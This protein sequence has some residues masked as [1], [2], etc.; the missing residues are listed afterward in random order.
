MYNYP[1][2]EITLI[3]YISQP[4]GQYIIC[5]CFSKKA[6]KSL[7]EEPM[8]IYHQHTCSVSKDGNINKGILCTCGRSVYIYEDR[9]F[10]NGVLHSNGDNNS[11]IG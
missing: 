5:C 2:L 10:R 7:P 4:M 11:A 3:F 9:Y 8:I 6:I 1:Y